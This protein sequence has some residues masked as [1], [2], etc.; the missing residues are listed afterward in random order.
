VPGEETGDGKR[1]TGDEQ[2]LVAKMSRS[3]V[4]VIFDA[5]DAFDLPPATRNLC[6]LC[7]LS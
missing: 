4:L 1:E 3:L 5:F 6:N 2:R 7:N